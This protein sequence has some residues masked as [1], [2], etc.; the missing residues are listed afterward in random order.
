[1]I[2]CNHC[3]NQCA[4]HTSFCP[5]CGAQLQTGYS[6]QPNGYAQQPYGN[7]YGQQ[8]VQEDKPETGLC[9]LSFFFWIVG[10]VLYAV[11]VSTKPIAAKAYLKWGLISLGVGVGLSLLLTLIPLLFTVSILRW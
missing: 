9:V 2:Y 10:I 7:Y 11:N 1:M 6:Q 4:D 8:P 3:G 5:V